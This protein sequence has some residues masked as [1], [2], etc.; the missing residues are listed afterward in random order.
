MT[1]NITTIAFI[2][3][4]FSM[5]AQ[6]M[7]EIFTNLPDSILPTLTKNNRLDC[8]DFIENKMTTEVNNSLN[9]KS[10]L[11]ALT[12]NLAKIKISELA[13]LQICKIPID[14][15]YIICLIHS[16]KADAWDSSIKF[17][18]P[19][20]TPINASQFITLPTTKDFIPQPADKN[21]VAYQNILNKANYPFIRINFDGIDLTFTYTSSN[22][23]DEDFK[24][25]V[26][27]FVKPVIKMVWDKE[28]HCFKR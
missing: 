8:I 18:K 12:E 10:C 27:P 2:L 7:K 1:K 21:E 22:N 13:E 3:I 5:H 11:T 20:W 28:R 25:E 24:S 19:N 9:G 6:T 15:N 14:N 26:L 4:T 23:N 17:Y 16:C